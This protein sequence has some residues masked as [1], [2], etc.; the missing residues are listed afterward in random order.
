M[1]SATIENNNSATNLNIKKLK[2]FTVSE[3]ACINRDTYS[4][5]IELIFPY[6]RTRRTP[7]PR[8]HIYLFIVFVDGLPANAY[9]YYFLSIKSERESMVK[10]YMGCDTF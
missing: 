6:Q 3:T 4:T 10:V 1:K 8:F 5:R 7:S 9:P 2:N